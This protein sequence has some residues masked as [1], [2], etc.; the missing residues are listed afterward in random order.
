MGLGTVDNATL[1]ISIPTLKGKRITH[2]GCG[3]EHSIFVEGIYLLKWKSWKNT[4]SS[5]IYSCGKSDRG[6]L[7]MGDN[8][9]RIVPNRVEL[10]S[11]LSL[12]KEKIAAVACGFAHTVI[13]TTVGSVYSTGSGDQV[14]LT[15]YLTL[16]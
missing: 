14:K 16:D 4:D 1:P 3:G 7:G 9:T 11:N 15:K 13:L 8:L 10:N 6:Q 5:V 12:K 2:V